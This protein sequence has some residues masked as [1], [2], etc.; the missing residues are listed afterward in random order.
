MIHEGRPPHVGGASEPLRRVQRR[1]SA[2]SPPKRPSQRIRR[3]HARHA[4]RSQRRDPP[5]TRPTHSGLSI[6]EDR[7][8]TALYLWTVLWRWAQPQG[9]AADSA[10]I[11]VSARTVGTLCDADVS[12]GVLRGACA[13]RRICGCHDQAQAQLQS[14]WGHRHTD[15]NVC[16]HR[17][18]EASR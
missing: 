13:Q 18:T 3:S 14:L 5:T 9:N 4:H 6:R 16:K 15:V 2:L 17:R 8:R 10:S 7:R 12:L 1:L 11:C